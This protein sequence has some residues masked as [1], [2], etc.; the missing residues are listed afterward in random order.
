MGSQRGG[1]GAEPQNAGEVFKKFVKNQW[2][3]YNFLKRFK[4]ISLFFQQFF[5]NLSKFWRK[6]GQKFR[7]LRNMHWSKVRGGRAPSNVREF[8]EIWVEKLMETFNFW[9]VL[10]EILPFFN[11]F[12]NFIEFFGKIAPIISENMD[13]CIF[14][15]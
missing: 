14:G 13:I 12:K 11:F 6:F 4:E 9:M 5:K 1:C 10:M 7:N 8:M 15:G 3:I 2:K